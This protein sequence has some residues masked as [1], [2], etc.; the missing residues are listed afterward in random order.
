M[1]TGVY[2]VQ[3]LLSNIGVNVGNSEIS[4][5]FGGLF[6]TFK[7][8]ELKK[9]LK[10]VKCLNASDMNSNHMSLNRQLQRS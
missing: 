3:E 6:N 5:H 10:G 1:S 7:V 9:K 4:L 2:Q 8:M